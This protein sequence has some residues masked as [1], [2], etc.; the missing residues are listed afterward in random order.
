MADYELPILRNGPDVYENLNENAIHNILPARYVK[1]DMSGRPV[2]ESHEVFDRVAKNLAIPELIYADGNPVEIT[3]YEIKP[4]HPH[5]DEIIDE[6]FASSDI[7]ELSEENA[8]YVEYLPLLG[9]LKEEHHRELLSETYKKFKKMMEGLKFIPNSP[10]LMNAGDELQQLSACF[11]ISPEDDIAEIHQT[12]KEAALTFQSGGGMGYGFW[13]LRPKGSQVGSTG[14][15]ASGPITFM[16]TFDQ[17]CETIAQGGMRRGAQM[18]VMK[19]DHPDVI[20]FI[21]AKRKDVSLAES[22]RLNDPDDFTH[23]S[24]ADAL[25]EARELI[26]ENGRVPEHLRNAVEGHLSNF[27]ISVGVTNDFMR[28]LENDEM[29]TFREPSTGEP[30]VAN[31]QTEETCSMFGLGAYVKEGEVME[32]PASLIWEMMIEGAHENGEPG[33]VFIDRFNEE[34]SFPID[35]TKPLQDQDYV[36]LATN[37]CG[38]Q[39]LM[40]Y[41]ACNLGHINLSTIVSEDGKN[42]LEFGMESESEED[43]IEWFLDQAIDWEEFNKRIETS[44][45]FLDNVVTMSDFPIPEIEETV[46]RNRKIGLGIMGLAQ[47][48][49]QLGVRYGSPEANEMSRKIMQHINWE[50]KLVSNRLA[51]NRGNF[52]NWNDSKYADPLGNR[53]WFEN[54]TGENAIDW[55]DGFDIRNHNTTTIAPTGTTAMIGNTSGGCEPI[56]SVANYKNVSSDVQGD[57]MLVEFDSLFLAT[58]E[59]NGIDVEAVKTEAQELMAS[60]KFDGPESL[61]LVPDEIGELFVTTSD[62]TA[63]EHASV[64]CALQDGVDSA[65]S[66][67]VNAPNDSTLEDAKNAFEH[68]YQNG[69]KGVTYYRDGSR[70][71]QVLTTRA[72]NQAVEDGE[73]TENEEVSTTE[74]EQ[75]KMFPLTNGGKN[76]RR[77]PKR[78]DG[79]TY[80]IATG[81]GTM[82]V[83]VN[84]VAGEPFELLATVGKSGGTIESMLE[85]IARMVSLS[86]RSG[87]GPEE[88]ISQLEGIRS[89]QVGWDEGDSVESIPDAI[90]K[91][92]KRHT[93]VE[94]TADGG[95]IAKD[96]GKNI[97]PSIE[98][99]SEDAPLSKNMSSISGEYCPSCQR[100]SLHMTEGCM[101]CEECGWSAC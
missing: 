26:D 1:R 77:R 42:W 68:V 93:R 45:H 41:E 79:N 53:E 40:E 33:V 72:D 49:I 87:M 28:A 12:A 86:F 56:F 46:S 73:D 95:A 17:M 37:P 64:Q 84:D 96:T 75:S 27:N 47:L 7:V 81:Y 50:S 55:P 6:V 83:T 39:P 65:I 100:M 91:V 32:A 61:T 85:G 15:Y 51:Q 20:E 22:L 59:K 5:R 78:L 90:A 97:R 8:K 3:R 98:K 30:F 82:Y 18:G 23:N 52:S 92:L 29:F 4:D 69:G 101:T 71:K 21:H 80:K 2:E 24:F 43:R 70:T 48:L 89:P 88:V 19:V 13:T 14:G 25:E 60:N 58:L 38:E 76:Y 62:L 67:T 36:M 9:S 63:I 57:E 94:M 44:T 35:I 10:T 74:R 34:H 99:S 66:K 31:E 54:H 16:R 11:V